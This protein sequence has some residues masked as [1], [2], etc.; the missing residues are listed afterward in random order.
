MLKKCDVFLWLKNKKETKYKHL[1]RRKGM[2]TKILQIN[3]SKHFN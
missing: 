1:K 3:T 2:S